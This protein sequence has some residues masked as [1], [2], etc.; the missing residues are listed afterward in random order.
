MFVAVA[1][2]SDTPAL[3]GVEVEV[4]AKNVSVGDT[5]SELINDRDIDLVVISTNG[6]SGMRRLVMGSVTD[7]VVRGTH[8]PVLVLPPGDGEV[9]DLRR[10]MVALDGSLEAER[11]LSATTVLAQASGSE[12]ILAHVPVEIGEDADA[13][14]PYLDRVARAVKDRDLEVSTVIGGLEPAESISALATERR[15][16]MVVVATHGRGGLQ[17]AVIGSVADAVLRSSEVPVLLVP[18]LE[19]RAPDQITVS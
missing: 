6:R 14:G 12:V 15:A 13:M 9:G 18:I 10:I 4:V 3:P 2:E 17:R 5:L 7:A 1:D 8:R 19:R 11:S 16:D